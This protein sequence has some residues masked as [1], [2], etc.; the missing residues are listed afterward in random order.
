MKEI[1]ELLH[2]IKFTD[3]NEMIQI[4]KG[5]YEYPSNFK[6]LKLKIKEKFNNK[7]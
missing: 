1:I 4:A 3:G 6:L 2:L 7:K 5:K